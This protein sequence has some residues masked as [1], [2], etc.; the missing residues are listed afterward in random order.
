M[1][2]LAEALRVVLEPTVTAR[3][4]GD[5]RTGKRLNMRRVLDYVASGYRRD[6]IWLRRTRPSKRCD[7]RFIAL[8]A[9]ES[10]HVSRGVRIEVLRQAASRASRARGWLAASAAGPRRSSGR[11]P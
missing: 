3:L 2:R 9:L 10:V 6:K 11:R 7:Q 8:D 1:R 4:K 5:Y